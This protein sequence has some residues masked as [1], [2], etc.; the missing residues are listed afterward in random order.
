LWREKEFA[1]SNT[2]KLRGHG[3]WRDKKFAVSNTSK[4]RGRSHRARSRFVERQ[5][6]RCVE[7]KRT[8]RSRC[9]KKEK[10]RCIE[11]KRTWGMDGETGLTGTWNVCICLLLLSSATHRFI[12][13]YHLIRCLYYL[14]HRQMMKMCPVPEWRTAYIQ[15]ILA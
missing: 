5:E 3:V 14:I 12:N 4:F 9:V 1:V 10:V 8:W 13:I 6:I 11:Y 15:F 2:S 7:Y